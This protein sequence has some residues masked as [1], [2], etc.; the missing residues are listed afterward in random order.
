M[1]F[2]IRNDPSIITSKAI[3]F[4]CR[5][6]ASMDCFTAFNPRD[7]GVFSKKYLKIGPLNELGASLPLAPTIRVEFSK[8]S[9]SVFQ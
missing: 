6:R 3:H 9:S 5:G 1:F 8:Q 7:D 4:V 2:E